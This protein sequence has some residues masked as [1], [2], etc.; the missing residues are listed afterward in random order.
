MT[1]PRTDDS[2]LFTLNSIRLIDWMVR[3]DS[4]PTPLLDLL[5]VDPIE[6]DQD[7]GL[8]D[9]AQALVAT[10]AAG[11]REGTLVLGPTAAPLAAS[12]EATQAS[13]LMV[14]FRGELAQAIRLVDGGGFR[15]LLTAEPPGLVRCGRLDAAPPITDV[16]AA[17]VDD[18]LGDGASMVA[19]AVDIPSEVL[20]AKV[21]RGAAAGTL[22]WSI[23][24]ET[25][26]VIIDNLSSADV[27]ALLEP[28]FSQNI[29]PYGQ[30]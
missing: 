1:E 6:D 2:A 8:S 13:A 29:K 20:V 22:K 17:A 4:G 28:A 7:P 9:G 26:P 10:G 3:G 27:G 24:D 11:I 16:I 23:D 30:I 5:G 15:H 18:L 21:E 25:D 19:L 14:G 12:I